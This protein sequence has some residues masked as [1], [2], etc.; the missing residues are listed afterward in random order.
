MQDRVCPDSH[1]C[2]VT[3]TKARSSPYLALQLI[4]LTVASNIIALIVDLSEAEGHPGEFGYP[5]HRDDE[6]DEENQEG[7]TSWYSRPYAHI[8]K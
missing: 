7:P 2:I 1:L 8:T 5:E 3:S 4:G 6:E